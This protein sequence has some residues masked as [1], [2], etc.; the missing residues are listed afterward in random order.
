MSLIASPS[1]IDLDVTVW[2]LSTQ[3]PSTVQDGRNPELANAGEVPVPE[4][5]TLCLGV[6]GLGFRV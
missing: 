1:S 5:A 4:D 6:P 2:V 3:D